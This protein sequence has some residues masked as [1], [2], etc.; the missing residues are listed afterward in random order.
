MT[1]RIL[2]VTDERGTPEIQGGGMSY[3]MSVLRPAIKLGHEVEYITAEDYR[4]PYDGR[5]LKEH[6]TKTVSEF[7]PDV[8]NVFNNCI[9]GFDIFRELDRMGVPSVL[10]SPDYSIICKT[11]MLL[12][13]LERI[14]DGPS[15][16]CDGCPNLRI[17]VG[18]DEDI[19][20]DMLDRRIIVISEFM[21]RKLIEVG[22]EPE[23]VEMIEVGIRP[24]SYKPLFDVESG[25]V[26]NITRI[27]FEKGIHHYFELAQMV[28]ELKWSLAGYPNVRFEK[29]GVD[30][31]G[32]LSEKDKLYRLRHSEMFVST[33]RWH[34]PAG[35][36]YLEAKACG[37]PIISFRL[38]GIPQYHEGIGSILLDYCDL[39]GMAEAVRRLHADKDLRIRLG[40]EGRKQIEE[41]N[42]ENILIHKTISVYDKVR[43][44]K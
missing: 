29:E 18:K 34:E 16:D 3:M 14:C 5:A 23:N 8:V 25:E 6:L 42:N 44:V 9:W 36:T 17:G 30:Y 43:G 7:D 39:N 15:K 41:R 31:L 37:K 27:A 22:Y 26:L 19:K 35:L 32:E 33:P 2:L 4:N 11:R 1:M 12:K 10:S 40:K 28:P 21:R 24:E 13:N 20:K 38:G